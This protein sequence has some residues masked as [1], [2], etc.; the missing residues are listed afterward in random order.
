[1]LLT[2]ETDY[3]L[4]ALLRLA[5]RKGWTA[6]RDLARQEEIPLAYLRGILA[7]LA[8]S[9]LVKAREGVRGGVRLAKDPGG[10]RFM[11]V[12]RASQGDLEVVRC[13]F[14][15][16]PCVNRRTCP[17]RRRLGGLQAMVVSELA[18][19]TLAEFL[20]GKDRARRGERRRKG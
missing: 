17:I 7:K 5:G 3:A 4:R 2:K 15:S 13:L 19:I 10:V 18:S 14:R 8:R 6:A 1:M 9:G 11:D 20:P 12:V 16:R